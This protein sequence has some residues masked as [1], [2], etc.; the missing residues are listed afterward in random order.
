MLANLPPGEADSF[1]VPLK[2]LP[3]YHPPSWR[4][5]D[6]GPNV[7]AGGAGTS[8]LGSG[9]GPGNSADLMAGSPYVVAPSSPSP[10]FQAPL[11]FTHAPRFPPF[12]ELGLGGPPPGPPPPPPANYPL[13]SL[14]SKPPPLPPPAM[15]PPMAMLQTAS[16]ERTSSL[17]F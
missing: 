1:C 12:A 10:Q 8:P 6:Q 17:Q 9:A 16:F 2:Y 4:R 14:A 7:P 3:Y 13:A 5:A 11:P 15:P